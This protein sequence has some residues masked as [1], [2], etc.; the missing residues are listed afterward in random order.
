MWN[1]FLRIGQNYIGKKVIH[2]ICKIEGKKIAFEI[3]W[4]S[5]QKE[6]AEAAAE[7]KT[8]EVVIVDKVDSQEIEEMSEAFKKVKKVIGQFMSTNPNLLGIIVSC[9]PDPTSNSKTMQPYFHSF[10]DQLCQVL[11]LPRLFLC[12]KSL[13]QHLKN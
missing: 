2:T 6:N 8:K 12:I 11:Q 5:K 9:S 13:L 3:F 10:F 7:K 1:P 4:P